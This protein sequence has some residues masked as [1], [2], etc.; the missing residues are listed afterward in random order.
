M[1]I[2]WKT[3]Y[4]AAMR[5][6]DRSKLRDLCEVARRAICDRMIELSNPLGG[7]HAADRKELEE[8]ETAC[9]ALALYEHA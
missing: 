9:R 8:L 4:C 5:E 2:D 3:P 7:R 1:S 6:R